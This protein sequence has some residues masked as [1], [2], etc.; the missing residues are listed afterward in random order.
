M[1]RFFLELHGK[2]AENSRC[3]HSY[4]ACFQHEQSCGYVLGEFKELRKNCEVALLSLDVSALCFA[5]DSICGYGAHLL[6]KASA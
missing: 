4:G 3:L 2:T 1:G 5:A 6:G